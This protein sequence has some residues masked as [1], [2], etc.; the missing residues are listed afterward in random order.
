MGMFNWVFKGVKVEK[1]QPKTRSS[2]AVMDLQPISTDFTAPSQQTSQ[3]VQ[4]DIGSKSFSGNGNAAS[5][6]FEN[7]ERHVNQGFNYDQN[8]FAGGGQFGIGSGFGAGSALGG[9][10][11][12]NRN[13]LVVTPSSNTEVTEVVANLT[14]GEACII[15]LEGLDVTDAQRRL[16]FLSGVVCAMNGSIKRLNAN[17]YVLTPRGIGVRKQQ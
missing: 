16:D 3:T 9:A 6:L 1:R 4:P 7:T 5:I 12:G 11:H 13:I 2:D 8:S 10:T 17:T 15:C 14:N